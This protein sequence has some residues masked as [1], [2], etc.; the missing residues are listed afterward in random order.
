M[1]P[2][3]TSIAREWESMSN[4]RSDGNISIAI[5]GMLGMVDASSVGQK[6][7]LYDTHNLCKFLPLYLVN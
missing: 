4:G 1:Q 3:H 5:E 2:Q 7:E 6:D